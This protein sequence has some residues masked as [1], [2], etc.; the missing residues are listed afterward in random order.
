MPLNDTTKMGIVF[1]LLY[2]ITSSFKNRFQNGLE[3]IHAYLKTG[4][5]Q[6]AQFDLK[7]QKLDMTLTIA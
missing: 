4:L 5:N 2:E 3:T 1:L 6:N 7:Q